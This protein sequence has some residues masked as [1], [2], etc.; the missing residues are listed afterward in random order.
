MVGLEGILVLEPSL[1]G[2]PYLL[3]RLLGGVD[4]PFPRMIQFRTKK[5]DRL[6]VLVCSPCWARASRNSCRKVDCQDQAGLRLD[7]VRGMIAT[8]RLGREFPS[9]RHCS[10]QRLVLD[11]LTWKRAAA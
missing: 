10:E 7:P 6:L 3:A 2:C 8:R 9:W 4:R 5:R 1:A 11:T